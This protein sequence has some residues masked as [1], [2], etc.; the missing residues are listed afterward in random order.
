MTEIGFLST[1]IISLNQK[2][3]T[4]LLMDHFSRIDY[5][6]YYESYLSPFVSYLKKFQP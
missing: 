1:F 4:F 6:D 2:Q 5:N 3:S